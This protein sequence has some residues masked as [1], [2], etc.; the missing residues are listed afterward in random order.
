MKLSV[1]IVNYNVKYFLE[2]CLY[3]VRAATSGLDAEVIVVDNHSMDGSVDYLR[4]RFPEV[5]FIENEDNPGFAYSNNQAICRSEGEYVLLLNPDTV[6]GEEGIR[7][8]C[9]FMDEHPEAGAIGVKMLDGHGIFL[10]ESKR[11]FPSPWV[12]FCKI[13]G[14]SRLR[15]N[16][17]KFARYN[18]PYLNENKQHEVEVLSGAFMLIRREALNKTGLLDEAFFMYGEDIDLSYRLTLAGYKNYYIP[19]R[20]LHY[21][22]ESTHHGDIK[23]IKAFYEAMLIFYRKYYSH[24]GWL[25]SLLV[26]LAIGM[27]AFFSFLFPYHRKNK[28]RRVKHRRLLILC[29]EEHFEEV[30]AVCLKHMPELEYVNLWDLDEERVMDAFCRRNQMKGFTDY[31]FCSPDAR[32]EQMLL[33]MDRMVNKKITYHIYNIV[34]KQLISP[35]K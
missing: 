34:S 24:S 22:G 25:M 10:P 35:G 16:S 18:L 3:S 12:S 2:Q 17:R 7:T 6:V 21:K 20:I 19:E 33:L 9:F 30:K 11:S 15:P 13:F 28:K 27:K 32:F 23:Y 5:V 8:L 4:T 31:A 29:N 26:R 1:I 14:L